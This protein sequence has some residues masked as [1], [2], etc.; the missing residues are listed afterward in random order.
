MTQTDN[1]GL[2]IADA[3][4]RMRDA[5]AVIRRGETPPARRTALAE[6]DRAIAEAS[7]LRAATWHDAQQKSEM[8]RVCL[9][10]RNAKAASIMTA[11]LS[12][13]LERLLKPEVRYAVP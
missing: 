5:L 2:T 11:S 9:M 6:L 3:A 7:R 4:A 10:G 8:I 1:A 13:D 12:R